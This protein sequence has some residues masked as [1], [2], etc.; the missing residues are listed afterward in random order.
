ME[1]A[2]G[3]ALAARLEAAGIAAAWARELIAAGL[4]VARFRELRFQAFAFVTEAEVDEALGPGAH[5]GAA[6]QVARDR[7]RDELAARALAEWTAEARGRARIRKLAATEG[8]WP[9][10]FSLDPGRER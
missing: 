4:K 5:D 6:R 10:P 9:A 7:L 3:A 1:T 8:P 2:G